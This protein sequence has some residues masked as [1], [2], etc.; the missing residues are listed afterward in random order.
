MKRVPRVGKSSVSC[1]KYRLSQGTGALMQ[2]RMLFQPFLVDLSLLLT[3]FSILIMITSFLTDP[4]I[5]ISIL[6]DS[7]TQLCYEP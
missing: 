6:E 2:S 3:N 7:R 5:M 4:F 1:Q